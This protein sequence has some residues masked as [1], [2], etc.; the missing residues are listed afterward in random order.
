DINTTDENGQT[1]LHLALRNDNFAIVK[2]LLDNGA[3]I[4]ILD[5]NGKSPFDIAVHYSSD[6]VI[7]LLE[8]VRTALEKARV[9]KKG[10][11]ELDN[12]I[13]EPLATKDFEA[14]LKSGVDVNNKKFGDTPLN[15][16]ISHKRR[17]EKVELLLKYGANPNI[18]NS[19][20]KTPLHKAIELA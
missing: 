10:P 9:E 11:A 4:N 19:E 6:E 8:K 17:P 15:K 12:A 3:D 2:F 13:D 1:P 16:V 18:K 14:I 5:K 20:G 7:G